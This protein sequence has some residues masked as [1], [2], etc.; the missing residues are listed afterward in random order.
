MTHS[1]GSENVP[2]ERFHSYLEG[3]SGN[4]TYSNINRF[5]SVTFEGLQILRRCNNFRYD[6][7]QAFATRLRAAT[8]D[9]EARIVCLGGHPSK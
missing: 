4:T 5:C 2:F 8:G 7:I 1:D 9:T 3:K 6:M